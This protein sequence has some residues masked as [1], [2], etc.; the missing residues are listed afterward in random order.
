MAPTKTANGSRTAARTAGGTSTPARRR[1]AGTGGGRPLVIVESPTKAGKIAGYLGNDYVVEASVGHIRD[2]PRNAADVP[3]EHKGAPWARLGVDVDNAFEP[4]YVISP[5]RKQQVSRLKQL[6]KDA[7]EVYLATDEDR[8]GE[9]IAWHLVDTLK[10]RVPVRRMVFHEITPEAIARAVANPR[11]LD[12]SLVDAQETRRILDRLYGYEVSPVL[13]KKVLPKLSAGRVQS[14]ATRI[15]VERE[16][17]RM[18]FRSADYWSLEGTFAVTEQNG[19]AD[20][21][22]PATLRARLVSIDDSRV[23]TGRDFDPA[24]GQVTGEV[25]HLD[26]AGARGLAAR[27]EGR[28][29]T[30][31]RVDEKPYR[32]RPY[33]PFIT[34]TLQ[35]E[36]GRKLGWSSAQVMR[37]AQRLYENGH[38]TYMRT[39][40]TNLSDE[41]V[42][43]ARTQARELYGDAFVPAEARRYAKKVKGAQEAHEAIRPAGDSFRT[44]GQLAGRLAR[45]EFRLYELIWQRTIASQM[46]DAV[47][48]SVSIRLAGRSSTDEAVE[49]TASGRTITFP[50]FLRAY[51]ESRDE[52]A[53]GDDDHGSDDAERRLPRVERGQRLDTRELEAR[54]HTTTP[55]SRYTEPSLVARLQDLNIGRPSTYASIMQTIQ[56]RGYVWKK[57]SA[58]VPS[59]TAFAVVNLLEQH[60]AALVDYDFTA[61]LEN[62]LD[63]IANGALGRVDWLT[64]F[65]FGGEGRHAGGIAASGGLKQVIGQQLEEIDARGVNSIPL[66]APGPD[67][68]PVVVRVGRYGPYLQ[69]G[70][71]DG[72]R[73]SLPEDLA[74][75]ELTEEKVAE[76]L[77][78]PSGD[79]ELGTDP[80]TGLPIVVKAGRYGP[81]VTTVVPEGSSEAARTASLFASMSPETVTLDDALRLLTL[82]RT[83]GTAPD[84]EEVQALNGRYGPYLKKGSDSRSLESEDRLFTVTLDQA[85]ALFAQPKQR[86]RR[87]AAAPLKEL[88][89][90]PVTQGAITVREGRFGPYVTDGETNAS[91]R[92]GDDVESITLDRAVELLADRRARPATKKTAKKT[93]AKKTTAKKTTA[94]AAKKTPTR[95]TARKAGTDAVPAG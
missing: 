37:V 92:K 71:E 48:Q 89:P 86:G 52:G 50:G 88:G 29:V 8:E 4:L 16:R 20:E 68:E 57:G 33:A 14:V 7:S 19:G 6:L 80:Q 46:A 10:P 60:F 38:I 95:K 45:D 61:T 90:D 39:D 32:R 69:A 18:A 70:G 62:E 53:A 36:A 5:D 77:A 75:D 27:L 51:V 72:P 3:A 84:G 9:A 47:G 12:Q 59:F 28:Q 64:E 55:P 79:R 54:G 30:V 74:P 44:P 23:A 78:A 56:D 81:Y 17:E 83:V 63:E 58:L 35:M 43:A 66:R 49:F 65:Y 40:S 73:V 11:E 91:L 82:P 13:W 22:E 25:V 67:G 2:L 85:L 34:S 1:T 94:T 42:N 24:T 26:E 41:A 87:A 15:V 76:L 21:G 93:T 31:S